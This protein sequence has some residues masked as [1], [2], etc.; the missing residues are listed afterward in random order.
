MKRLA[1]LSGIALILSVATDAVAA[2]ADETVHTVEPGETLNGIANR[3]E[4]PREK[5][6]EA[7]DLEPPYIL[8]VG[9][10]LE[11]P[12]GTNSSSQSNLPPE[13]T[14]EYIVKPGD[15]LSSIAIHT[16]VPRVLIAEAN[17]L[18]APFV[19]RVG[20]K[21]FIPRTRHH[22]VESGE[23]G[24]GIAAKYGVGW[25]EIAVANNI[26]EDAPIKVGQVLLIP[27]ILDVEKTEPS[28]KPAPPPKPKI[29]FMWPVSGDI[30]RG[31]RPRDQRNY[32]DGLDIAAPRG[33]AVRATEAGRVIFAADKDEFGNLV[34]IDHSNGWH[35]AYG[36][37]SRI[38]VRK[39]ERVS[40][41][42]RIGLVGSTGVARGNELHFELRR[43]NR[44]VDPLTELP[45][46]P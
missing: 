9:Q 15:T 3:A 35:S 2:P 10:K 31:Y 16:K 30:R 29:S 20:Q 5:I 46:G 32:H 44:P 25:S 18:R 6:I 37:L 34:V 45:A 33:T 22:T 19:V 8:R 40:R 4:V 38:T 27:T 17:G 1:L 14:N 23:T 21:L 13:L 42:E 12:R 7:N 11:I 43:N 41:G 26:E 36:F 39:E 28:P 24:L